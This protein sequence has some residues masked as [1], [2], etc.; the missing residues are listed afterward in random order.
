MPPPK[1]DPRAGRA[2]ITYARGWQSLEATRSLGRLGVE[3]VTG[4]EFGLTPTS[5]SRFSIADFRYPNPTDKPERFLD[6][7]EE[8]ITRYKPE[9]PAT[10]YVLMP[11]HKE[12]YLIAQHRA[13]FEPH[14]KV[15]VPQI[16]QIEQVHNKGTLAAYAQDRGL[17][18]PR[19]WIPRSREEFAAQVPEITL[20]AF[21][22]LRESAAGV[23]IQKVKTV[24]ELEETFDDFVQRY[25]LRPVDYPI[26]QAAVPGD[27]YCVT[28]LFDRGSLVGLHDLPQPAPVSRG[29]RAP[30]WFGRRSKQSRWRPW[31]R[32]FLAPWAGTASRNSTSV[33]R[34]SRTRRST[35]L[36]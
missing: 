12:T 7:L 29:R 31:R 35:S 24:S 14:I 10:P 1:R 22:K 36:K 32:T 15:P 23:G 27:D 4:D 33:G 21:V 25:A 17:S 3:V 18:M 2:I 19:T 11:V 20:P 34:V 5:F 13:R 30:A 16:A 9:D 8:T 28:T 26:I 6:V